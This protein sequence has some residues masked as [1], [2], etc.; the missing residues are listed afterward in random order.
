[1]ITRGIA[2]LCL[3]A[4][5]GAPALAAGGDAGA[6]TADAG[7]AGSAGAT[8]SFDRA[9]AQRLAG[10]ALA[11]IKEGSWGEAAELLRVAHDKDAKNAAIATDLGYTLTH[12]GVREEAERLFRQAIELDPRRFYAYV[13]LAELWSTDP[14]RWQRR[15]EMVAFLEKALETLAGDAKASANIELKLAELQRSLGRAAD[16]RA[17]LQRLGR[18]TVPVQVRQRAT[19]LMDEVDAEARAR[20]L[21]DWPAPTVAR[22]D[23][24]RLAKAHAM[25]DER[26]ALE[27]L[28][29]LVA[30][31]PAW[32][33]ARWERARVLERLGQLDDASAELTI[34]VQLAPTHALA[35]R[36]LG[37]ILA[38]HGGRFEAERADE[39]LRQALALEPSWADLREL[40]NQVAAK[41]TRG[42]HKSEGESVPEPTARARQL[43]EDAQSW[44]GMEAPEL[45]APLLRQALAESP[46]FVEAAVALYNLEHAVPA[47]AVKALWNDGAALWRLATQVTAL[48]TREAAALAR[49][50]IDRAVELGVQEARF[51]RASLRAAAGDRPG[52]LEDLRNYVAAEPSPPRLEEAR[53]L[54]VTLGA[55]TVADSPERLVHLRLAADKPAEALAALG[56]SC[57]VG[58]PVDNLLALGHVYEYMGDAGRALACYH[59]AIG[60]GAQAS[61][62]QMQRAWERLGAV[63]AALPAGELERLRP[64]LQEAAR[65]GVAPASLALARLDEAHALW[66]DAEWELRVFFKGA[67]ADEPRLAEAREIQQRVRV[68]ME[69]ERVEQKQRVR[70]GL[71]LA[72]GAALILLVLAFRRWA[73]RFSLRR[74]LRSQPLL[75]PA[76]SQ[77]IG[78]VRHDVIKHRAS[79][80]ELLSDP[81]TN[82]EDVVRA[83]LEPMPA[84]CE[85]TGIFEQLVQEARGLGVRLRPLGR[86]PVF[87]PLV[88]DLE[89]VEELLGRNDPRHDAELR[90]LDQRLRGPHADGLQRLLRSGPRTRLDAG[91]LLRWIDGVASEPGRPAWVAPGLFLQEAQ[92][93]FPMNESTLRS[94]FSNLLRN[95]VDAVAQQPS[96]SVQ[97][98]VE[99]GR[100][101]TGRRTV[102]LMIV[103]SSPR[104]LRE[105]DIEA[106]AADRGLGI[107]RETARRWG[108]QIFVRPE[109]APFRKAVGVQ[110]SA[111]PE[112]VA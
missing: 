80:L 3:L 90:V 65:A 11:K 88:R 104:T 108:G 54:R 59:I 5:A 7:E 107:V 33:E 99:Q 92:I 48:R 74:A 97:V 9:G 61:A 19:R 67:S 70:R 86:E 16:A 8:D 110:F 64:S 96:R 47:T 109:P 84:S 52:A 14:M 6:D 17:R 53:A 4:A 89:H 85:V 32:H 45:A 60:S 23:R 63:A 43:L 78:K 75:F 69:Q 112:E 37:Q 12:L 50:W 76:L 62:A 22:E 1:M 73:R 27:I 100:D 46:G 93:A 95:A 49:P 13:N 71:A 28:D 91:L 42:G 66:P 15:D 41:R 24:D 55:A 82:R 56:G 72:G 30:R 2:L 94:I 29:A 103:D 44:I 79:A 26:G 25:A 35:W 31:W 87:G 51:A 57:A 38:L 18:A 101:G 77:A 68:A 10:K 58:L 98:R 106:R 21:E 111:P 83:L 40:R 36:H 102:S 81:T 39:A 20:A 34:V 105:E